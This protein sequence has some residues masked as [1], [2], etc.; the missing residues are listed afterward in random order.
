MIFGKAMALYVKKSVCV[1]TQI[2]TDSIL[3]F[4]YT[5]ADTDGAV[6]NKVSYFKA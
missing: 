2:F 4:V 5:I 3:F 6:K 1:N